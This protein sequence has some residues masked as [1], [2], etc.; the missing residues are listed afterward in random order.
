MRRY[1]TIIDSKYSGRL[2]QNKDEFLR[3]LEKMKNKITDIYSR[4]KIS[5][6]HYNT[7]YKKI[8]DYENEYSKSDLS[9]GSEK[10]N[11]E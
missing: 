7:L 4:G 1:L 11:K 2:P 6:S 8:T 5:D 3:E 9:S 10:E